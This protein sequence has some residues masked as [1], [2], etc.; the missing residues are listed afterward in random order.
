MAL[1]KPG[2]AI[3]QASGRVGGTI[4][5]HN[6]GGMYMRNGTKPKVVVSDAAM[7]QKAIMGVCSRAWAT[8]DNSQRA[9]WR[10]W[11]VE[12]P[13]INRLGE[14]RTLSGSQAYNQIN[15]R[16]LRCGG[17]ALSLPPIGGPPVPLTTLSAAADASDGTLVLTFAATPIPANT[18]YMV[19]GCPVNSEAVT[20]YKNR[21]VLV[22]ILPATTATGADIGSDWEGRFGSLIEG[23]NLKLEAQAIS[24]TTGLI[25]GFV[26]AEATVAA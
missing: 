13:V 15:A 9:A 17:S 2:V 23:Q 12:N 22:S 3:S 18:A 11:A 4:F 21:M 6:R 26:R 1:F 20:Y 14:S 16:L 19:W 8:L 25:S 7:E 24:L 5:S 10:T